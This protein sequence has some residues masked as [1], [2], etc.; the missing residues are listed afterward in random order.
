MEEKEVNKK[1]LNLACGNNR[2]EDYFGIDIVQT[3]TT[4]RVMDLQKYPWDIES[5]SIEKIICSHYIEHINHDSVMKDFIEALSI[6]TTFESFKIELLNRVEYIGNAIN[7]PFIPSDGLFRFMDE[8]YRILIPGGKIKIIAPYYASARHMQDPTHVRSIG[9]ET[10][11]YFMKDWRKANG[12]D[13]YKV[14]CDFTFTY[15]FNIK[16]EYSMK[17]EEQRN[18][19]MSHYWNI[20]D[21][22]DATLTKVV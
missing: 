21:D 6:S 20:I 14:N 4:D 11:L 9:G 18:F 19:A 22:I 12:L 10:L 1:K 7:Y 3:E 16:S 17:H 15:W 5:N 8:V 2:F 13:H